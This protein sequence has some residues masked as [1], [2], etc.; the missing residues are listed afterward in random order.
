MNTC[1]ICRAACLL[2]TVLSLF[3]ARTAE[4]P[5]ADSG[6][7]VGAW[8]EFT[9]LEFHGLRTYAP[10]EIVNAL[11]QSPE[12]LL[13]AHPAAPRAEF[14]PAL[15]KALVNGFRNGGFRDAQVGVTLDEARQRVRVELTEGPRFRCGTV[16][17]V[18]AKKLPVAEVVRRLTE[19]TMVQP[20]TATGE[21]F[22]MLKAQQAAM[23]QTITWKAGD[24]VSF[25]AP[26][27]ERRR[28]E[29]EKVLSACGFHFAKFALRLEPQPTGDRMDLVVDVLAEGAA[30]KLGQIE[31]T[32]L[33]R[34]TPAQFL[35]WLGVKPGDPLA[36]D[37]VPKLERRIADSGRFLMQRVT[38]EQVL[39]DAGQVGL[40]IE[41]REFTNSPL[42]GQ[43]FSSTE[44]HLLRGRAWLEA[45]FLRGEELVYE[46]RLTN[47][48]VATNLG[49][50]LNGRVQLVLRRDAV[51]LVQWAGDKLERGLVITTNGLHYASGVS[52]RR[53]ESP[54]GANIRVNGAVRFG[55]NPEFSGT[56]APENVSAEFGLARWGGEV[57]RP[58][59]LGFDITPGLM[60]HNARKPGTKLRVERGI[61]YISNEEEAWQIRATSGELVEYSVRGKVDEGGEQAV[62]LRPQRGAIAAAELGLRAA[63]AGRPNLC[64]TNRPLGSAVGVMIAELTESPLL[65]LALPK[66]GP[67]RIKPLASALQRLAMGG[68]LDPLEQ[69]LGGNFTRETFSV[70]TELPPPNVPA[71]MRMFWGQMS[72][73]VHR[74][75]Q[76]HLPAVSWPA[77]LTREAVMIFGG[78]PKYAD[79]ELTRLLESPQTGPIGC[80]AAAGLL[81]QA[82]NEAGAARFAERG[83]QRLSAEDFRRD[84]A[85]LLDIADNYTRRAGRPLAA[86]TTLP[87]DELAALMSLLQPSTRGFLVRAIAAVKTQPDRGLREVLEPL[88]ADWWQGG[89]Q[90]EIEALLQRAQGGASARLAAQKLFVEAVARLEGKDGLAAN[91]TEAV[92]LFRQAAQQGSAGAAY[93]L[94]ALHEKGV[95]VERD[96]PEALKWFGLAATN[97]VTE[98]QMK[99]GDVHSNGLDAPTDLV[100]AVFWY[101]LAEL[102]GNRVAG[103]FAS[104]LDRRLTPEQ[105]KQVMERIQSALGA[106]ASGQAQPRKPDQP[107]R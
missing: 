74:F 79:P 15:Q 52:G 72:A 41:V 91:P 37:Y 73:W 103:V 47:V 4:P 11:L 61:A 51:A 98:A 44:Q 60:I 99:L 75:I 39:G 48:V 80:L 49:F 83:L 5:R 23:Q 63:G 13:A 86:L 68:L 95:G 96:F 81:A 35:T 24:A 67:E 22:Q 38:P 6:P 28:A 93:Y 8:G 54:V 97:G 3:P 57:I 92:R 82:G 1:S 29:V 78:N 87:A 17:V 94:G 33:T 43:A 30:G 104:G 27:A 42:L 90:K 18:N 62:T 85:L 55:L 46:A 105:R 16:R 101:R 25:D 100:T 70:P 31:V 53:F 56:N 21:V 50:K 84:A 71:M 88:L 12:F 14:A 20:E 77:T 66:G 10:N 76:E 45:A 19:K 32:G 69:F 2:L 26:T 102:G 58:V 40:K 7:R 64:A 106:N 36:F 9:R 59:D 89:L 34:H 65:H 107:A